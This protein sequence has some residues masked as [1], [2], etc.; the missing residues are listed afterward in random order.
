[1]RAFFPCLTTPFY[2]AAPDNT[3][4]EFWK[5]LLEVASIK[6]GYFVPQDVLFFVWLSYGIL[7]TFAFVGTEVLVWDIPDFPSAQSPKGYLAMAG[8]LVGDIA[9]IYTRI[10]A[11]LRC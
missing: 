4:K 11:E 6:F 7:K 3:L 8:I 2:F 9:I 10:Q 5:T 1:M